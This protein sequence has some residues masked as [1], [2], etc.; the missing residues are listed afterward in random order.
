MKI[1]IALLVPILLGIVVGSNLSS[2]M[3][4]VIL[5]QPTVALPIGGWLMMAIGLGI[6]SSISIQLA[7]FI[8][9]RR[10][11]RQIRQLQSRLQQT[12][13]D[14]FTYTSP[15]SKPDRS[16]P[17]KPVS[18]AAENE[19][20][21]P[22]KTSRFSSYRS[23][24]KAQF[25]SKPSA[26]P[27]TIDDRDDWAAEPRSNRQLDWEDPIPPRPQ[28]LQSPNNRS[29]IDNAQIYPNRRT[30]TVESE[31][32][33]I[34]REV[35]DADFRLIQPPYK[36]PVETEFEDDRGSADFE[37]TEIDEDEDFDLSS[38]SVQ[39]TA[40]N[41]STPSKNP[42]EEDWGFDFDDRDTPVRVN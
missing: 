33:E 8:D 15:A 6:L 23:R 20:P 5:N 24:V 42:E 37:Y 16:S 25:S 2:V 28:N 36:E 32:E 31:P 22:A 39:P 12:D 35:Y 29:T 3:T 40:P 21:S 34:R 9:R 10:L 19:N 26:Q 27:M 14:T 4:V 18:T 30:Q 1:V 7:I 17:E 41:R 13:E 38:S 11:Q